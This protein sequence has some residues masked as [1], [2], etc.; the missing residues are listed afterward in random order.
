MLVSGEVPHII[1][2]LVGL[3]APPALAVGAFKSP[4]SCALP[5]VAIVTKSIVFVIPPFVPPALIPL[6]E[7]E[8]PESSA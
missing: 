1:T 2:P 4:K 8:N 5:V 7:L 6:V 3:D